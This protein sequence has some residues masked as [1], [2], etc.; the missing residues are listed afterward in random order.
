[1]PIF[2]LKNLG[3]SGCQFPEV[4]PTVRWLLRRKWFFFATEKRRRVHLFLDFHG[5]AALTQADENKVDMK[6]N[7]SRAACSL[8]NSIRGII[9][10][11]K[12][13]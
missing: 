12:F 13:V 1:M 6:T 5:S 8:K 2:N 3:L 10:G 7:K 9:H 4:I 11:L